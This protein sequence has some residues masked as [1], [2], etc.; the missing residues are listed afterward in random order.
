MQH[1]TA[2]LTAMTILHT[3]LTLILGWLPIPISIP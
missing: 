1:M 2:H 3:I